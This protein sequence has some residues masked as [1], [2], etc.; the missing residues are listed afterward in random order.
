MSD[1][2]S[3]AA[4]LAPYLTL[5]ASSMGQAVIDSAQSRVAD[6]TVERGRSFLMRVLGRET[7]RL[8]AE[9][10]RSGAATEIAGLVESL[11]RAHR[12]AL[13]TAIGHWLLDHESGLTEE[14]LLRHIK[15]GAALAQPGSV[16]NTAHATGPGAI[17]VGQVVGDVHA[18]YRPGDAGDGR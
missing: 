12:N 10:G 6:S 5:A 1:L 13:E 11:D 17:A 18:G 15:R 3:L 4:Q 16:T 2:M 8:G 14:S 7:D 9:E